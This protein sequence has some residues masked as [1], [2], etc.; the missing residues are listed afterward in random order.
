MTS[1]NNTDQHKHV[2]SST[3]IMERVDMKVPLKKRRRTEPTLEEKIK[4]RLCRMRLECEESFEANT[5]QDVLADELLEKD[6]NYL[7]FKDEDKDTAFWRPSNGINL[8]VTDD[9]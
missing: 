5:I 6:L 7:I 4:T 2:C 8:T 9:G 3:C 1:N